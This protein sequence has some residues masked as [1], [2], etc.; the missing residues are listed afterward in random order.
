MSPWRWFT[1][2]R[3]KGADKSRERSFAADLRQLTLGAGEVFNG[4]AIVAVTKGLLQA[5]VSYI[6]G[7]PGAPVS[8]LIDVLADARDSVLKPLG[9]SFESSG[10]E[11][12]AAALLGA[13][14]QYP[15]RGAVTWK[16]IVG[17]NVASDALSNLASAGLTGG[18]LIIVGEDYGEG[19]SIIQ[20]RTHSTALKSC[21]PLIDPRYHMPKLVELTEQAF[22]LSE[23][24]HLPV[25]MLLRIRA[26]H[27]TGSFVCKDNRPATFNAR[28]PL[29]PHYDFGRIPLP[30]SIYE[31]ENSKFEERLPAARRFIVEHGL[32]EHFPGN[33]GR[34]GILM[35]G[36]VYGSVLRGLLRFGMADAVGHTEIP[37]LVLNVV[38]PLVPEQIASFIK[39]KDRVLVVEEGNPAYIEQEVCAIAQR[40]G[41]LCRIQGKDVLP[42]AGEYTPEVVRTGLTRWLAE[43]A[44]RNVAAQVSTRQESIEQQ[45]ERAR[46]ALADQMPV[47]SAGFCTGCPERP[48]YTA[49]KLVQ[50]EIGELH[51]SLDIGCNTF[52]SLPPFNMGNTVLGYGMSLASGGAIGAATGKPIVAVMGDGG[53]WHNGIVTGVANAQ[54]NHYDA[55]LIILE[56]G[57]AAATGQQH[58]PSSGTNPWGEPI[59]LS[60][61]SAL[62]A[63][64]VKWIRRVNSYEL[65]HTVDVLRAALN[66]RGNGL[67]VVI[68]DQECM[69]ARQRR[70]RRIRAEAERAGRPTH[71]ARFGVDAEVCVGDHSC[72]RLSGCPSLTVKPASDPL[73]AAPTAYVDETCQACGLCGSAAHAAS[74]CPSFYQAIRGVNAT[75]WQRFKYQVSNRLMDALGAS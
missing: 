40:Q 30:P 67:R 29:R 17:T 64:G 25:I 23:A 34:I 11:A 66:R 42:I 39:N 15:L 62:R 13:S 45:S 63:M 74:L 22:E 18:G 24:S 43:A 65:E 53:F 31:Q 12:G 37:L 71:Y 52:A 44:E 28:N 8:H 69:L 3:A 73:K 70:E 75:P 38:H 41:F 4:E 49:L 55:V 14:I 10:S 5:G 54:W 58:V 32:N 48:V 59:K 33:G 21:M 35:Q 1:N 16:S 36:G 9:I 26:C 56:N 7:Y 19:A 47:R 61:E 60:I 46:K 68:S 72:I 6:G 27:M 50:Q 51:I 20:E 2:R 57:Y